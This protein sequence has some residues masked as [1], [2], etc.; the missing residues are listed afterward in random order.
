MSLGEKLRSVADEFSRTAPP[1]ALRIIH[2]AI[3]GLVDG[4]AGERALKA[5][6]AMPAFELED[7]GGERV[8][9][10]DMLQRGPLVVHFYRGVW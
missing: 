4:G 9:S 5:G 3:Q 2:D 10:G 1:E 6:D 7:S 8:R